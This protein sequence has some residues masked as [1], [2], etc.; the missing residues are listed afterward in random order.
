MEVLNM[1]SI[2]AKL[3][4]RYKLK[5]AELTEMFGIG[6]DQLKEYESYDAHMTVLC[7]MLKAAKNKQQ[8]VET[9]EK[10]NVI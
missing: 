3:A 7:V 1:V 4:V 9:L 8:F 2:A 6:E 5:I 10:L